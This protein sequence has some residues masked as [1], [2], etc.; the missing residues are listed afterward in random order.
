[1]GHLPEELRPM[2]ETANALVERTRRVLRLLFVGAHAHRSDER[3]GDLS[4][5]GVH[6]IW[7]K[8]QFLNGFLNIS[9]GNSGSF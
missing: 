3:H 6:F 5:K 7:S 9:V 1:M 8:A 2:P 4:S